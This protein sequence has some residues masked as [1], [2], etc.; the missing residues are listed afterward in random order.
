M[1]VTTYQNMIIQII[2]PMITT[3][4]FKLTTP[5]P[6]ASRLWCFHLFLFSLLSKASALPIV[7]GTVSL[8]NCHVLIYKAVKINLGYTEP[9]NLLADCKDSKYNC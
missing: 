2:K 6:Q 3:C 1:P 4:P 9:R 7:H 8:I 5:L